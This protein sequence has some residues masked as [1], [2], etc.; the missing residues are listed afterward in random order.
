MRFIPESNWTPA[1]GFSL[2]AAADG[3][4]RSEDNTYVLAGPG[5]GKTELLAQRACY[6]LQTNNCQHPRRI[7]AISFKRD[8]AVNI[9]ERVKARCGDEL[10]RKFTSL[11]YDAFAKRILDQFMNALPAEYIPKHRYD[12]LVNYVD[13]YDTFRLLEPTVYNKYNR[14]QITRA[15]DNISIPFN[16]KPKSDLEAAAINVKK[17][18]LHGQQGLSCRLT[19]KTITKLSKYIILSNEIIKKAL[20]MTYSHVFLDE[21]QDTTTLQYEFIKTCFHNSDAVL[22]A[23]GDDK[24][25]IMV[26]AG[27]DRDIFNKFRDD[28]DATEQSLI[29]NHRSAPRLIHLQKLLAGQITGNEEEVQSSGEWDEE[30]GICEIWNYPNP[31]KEAKD[32]ANEIEQWFSDEELKPRDISVLV[33]QRPDRYTSDLISELKD[34]GILARNESYLQDLLAEDAAKVILNFMYSMLN[35]KARQEWID[36]L[37]LLRYF[38]GI[39][40][41]DDSSDSQMKLIE[42]DLSEHLQLIRAELEDVANKSTLEAVLWKILEIFDIQSF[43][44]HFPQYRRGSYLDELISSTAKHLWDE[45]EEYGDWLQAVQTF[46]GDFS[47]PIM[48]VHKSKGLEYDTVIFVGL[49]DSALWNF[50][51][52]QDE[53]SCT[54]FVALSRAKERVVFTFSDIRNTGFNDASQMQSKDSLSPLYNLLK[55]SGIVTE[56]T[57]NLEEE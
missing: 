4:V 36:L 34:K 17:A 23:V 11:T 25:R 13:L 19:F 28:F 33:R 6:L 20:Q 10:S 45:Y 43:K 53:E 52:L 27:A 51:N 8:A 5:S 2:E 18:Y 50:A 21:F 42:R 57:M 49:E 47:I 46:R 38:N 54:L 26:W 14:T 55:S 31:D 16:A 32:I 1:D 39:L 44:N 7:L 48:T 15:F 29:I 22:T 30:D 41:S 37:N 56:H 40:A 12:V 9:M 3:V 24:Q 35:K